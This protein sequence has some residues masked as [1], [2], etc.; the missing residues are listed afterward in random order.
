MLRFIL[1]HIRVPVFLAWKCHS[2]TRFL[3]K[4]KHAIDLRFTPTQVVLLKFI[5]LEFSNK[6]RHRFSISA[7]E[8]SYCCEACGVCLFCIIA[9]LLYSSLI[10][11]LDWRISTRFCHTVIALFTRHVF[12]YPAVLH[13]WSACVVSGV[14]FFIPSCFLFSFSI[15][16]DANAALWA[17]YI[18]HKLDLHSQQLTEHSRGT[19]LHG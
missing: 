10:S 4:E 7:G 17:E 2:H 19:E 18:C 5:R 11:S 15:Q 3:E 6:P 12:S 16:F 1:L 9:V 13:M 14:F 8:V